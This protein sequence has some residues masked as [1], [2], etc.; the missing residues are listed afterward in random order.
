MRWRPSRFG[1]LRVPPAQGIMAIAKF[2]T[3]NILDGLYDMLRDDAS[4]W[5]RLVGF[6]KFLVGAGTA[7]LAFRWLNP[8]AIGRTLRDMKWI[9]TTFKVGL[10]GAYT[11][12]LALKMGKLAWMFGIAGVVATG[13]VLATATPVADGTLDAHMDADGNLPGD[14]NYQQPEQKES[15]LS[16]IANTIGGWFGGGGG[17]GGLAQVAPPLHIRNHEWGHSFI[18]PCAVVVLRL[19]LIHI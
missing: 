12:L 1:I 18:N 3:N 9:L 10:K 7:L 5:E 6:G 2:S 8:L 11:K 19:S 13:A 16:G 4:W 15:W 17:F 14:P